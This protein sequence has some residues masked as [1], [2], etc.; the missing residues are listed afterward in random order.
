MTT[1]AYTLATTGYVIGAFQHSPMGTT[2]VPI[3]QSPTAAM[4]TQ[5]VTNL[6]SPSPPPGR[7]APIVPHFPAPSQGLAIPYMG[8]KAT[9][10]KSPRTIK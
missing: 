1:W 5:A 4:A 3:I 6:N 7:G 9:P 2:F 8:V 10:L